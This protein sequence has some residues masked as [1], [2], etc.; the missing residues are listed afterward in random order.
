MRPPEHGGAQDDADLRR[1]LRRWQG[2]GAVSL[3][4]LVLAFPAYRGVE[5]IRRVDALAAREAALV[6]AGE[7]LWAQTCAS[8]HGIGG[9][10]VDAAALNS[11]EFLGMVTDDQIHHLIASGIPGTR[12][13]AWWTEFGGPL[14]EEE[15]RAL[16]A[17][18]RSWE[19]TAPSRPDW[20]SPGQTEPERE[21]G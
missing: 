16:V 6:S 20:R 4:L 12:M 11:R 17:Y 2:A 10:G 13:P 14:N 21:E 5:S 8:C 7:E 18:I 3:L 15:I 9:Q 1:S 19:A